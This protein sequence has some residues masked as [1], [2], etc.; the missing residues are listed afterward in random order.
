[1]LTQNSLLDAIKQPS[2]LIDRCQ[3]LQVGVAYLR[4]RGLLSW[5]CSYC[6]TRPWWRRTSGGRNTAHG[7]H[8]LACWPWEGLLHTSAGCKPGQS[9][10]LKIQFSETSFK[11]QQFIFFIQWIANL[12]K[13]MLI[14]T[15]LLRIS[16]II[17]KF[18]RA[19]IDNFFSI[20]DSLCYSN[21][22][23]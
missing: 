18:S 15:Q 22:N 2:L 14:L 16:S 1:M 23:I 11:K 8:S 3:C 4:R 6:W 17:D 20:I 5:M 13:S 9:P 21:S 19:T 10:P 7:S 12:S